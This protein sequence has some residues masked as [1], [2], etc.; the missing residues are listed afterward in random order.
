MKRL[1]LMAM[2]V[3]ACGAQ[4]TPETLVNSLRVLSVTA[5]P[6][7]V[8]PG[9]VTT[10]TTLWGDPSRIGEVST[11]IWVGCDP[12][13]LDLGRSPC[14]D[15]SFLIQ[16]TKITSAPVGMRILGLG[17]DSVVYTPAATTFDVLDAGDPIRQSGSV[18]QV[19]VIVI[20]EDVASN[21]EGD[22]LTQLLQRVQDRTT[23]A[24]I[25][26]SRVL[27]SE[28]PAADRNHNPVITSLTF[29][30][31]EVP[32][33]AKLQVHEGEE[34]ALGADIPASSRENYVEQLPTGPVNK[35][36]EVIGAWYS[37]GGRFSQERFDIASTTPTTFYAPGNAKFPDDT[38]P[39]KR[40]GQ[41]WLVVR[42]NRGAQAYSAF[43]YWVCDGSTTPT[44]TGITP[45]ASASDSVRVSGTNLAN[46]LDIVIGDYALVNGSY[47]P[48][49]D[50]FL[51]SQPPLPPGTYPVKL[52]SKNCENSDTGLTYVVAESDGGTP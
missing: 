31:V 38:V 20:G 49:S 16:P 29:N 19:I 13:P 46:A 30:G 2:L 51:G 10:M 50:N 33:G 26:V 18:G 3:S 43:R 35:T 25:A 27:V 47:S 9:Q 44:V 11:Q 36:E 39:A 7:E 48:T 5:E 15:A 4:F 24:A 14:N 52:R 8:A 22:K 1:L 23:P 28:K 34:I 42:D 45:P 40:I 41:L 21:L 37:I 6:P 17:V 12:D 32:I